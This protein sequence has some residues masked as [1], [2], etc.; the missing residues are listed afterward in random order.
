[1][2]RARS[3][4]RLLRVILTCAALALAARPS[5]TAARWTEIPVL[6]ARAVAVA[7]AA[8]VGAPPVHVARR[9]LAVVRAPSPTNARLARAPLAPAPAPREAAP[10]PAEDV[11]LANCALLC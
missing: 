1:V 11:Y 2:L 8:P 3:W 10:R 9:I 7:Q 5:P 4:L 6:V